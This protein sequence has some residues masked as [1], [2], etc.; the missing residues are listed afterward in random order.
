MLPSLPSLSA[1][2]GA[3]CHGPPL[4]QVLSTVVSNTHGFVHDWAQRGWGLIPHK[5]EQWKERIANNPLQPPE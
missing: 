4:V 5:L 2:R 1:C 3:G